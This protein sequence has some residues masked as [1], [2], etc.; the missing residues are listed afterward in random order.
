MTSQGATASGVPWDMATACLPWK[1]SQYTVHTPSYHLIVP[2]CVAGGFPRLTTLL[3]LGEFNS[4]DGSCDAAPDG[5]AELVD[6]VK[7]LQ[8]RVGPAVTVWLHLSNRG[9][10]VQRRLLEHLRAA[11]PDPGRCHLVSPAVHA[12]P[13]YAQE[14]MDEA[15]DAVAGEL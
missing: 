13:D 3:V 7:M 4:E 11:V 10:M 12:L 6:L 15:A 5:L 8:H 2:I 1:L 14:D 9:Q